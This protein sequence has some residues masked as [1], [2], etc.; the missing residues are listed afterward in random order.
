MCSIHLGKV[1]IICFFKRRDMKK[2]TQL[3]LSNPKLKT[4]QAK[5]LSHPIYTSLSTH[6]DFKLFMERH[7][8]AVWDFL[9][10]VKELQRNVTNTKRFWTPCLDSN[11]A[12]FVN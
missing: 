12:R 9:L 5:L 3:L 4:T 8:W 11:A 1:L 2:M 6:A 10:L 7:C